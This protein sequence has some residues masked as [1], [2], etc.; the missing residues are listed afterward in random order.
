MHQ[1]ETVNADAMWASE[2]QQ[3]SADAYPQLLCG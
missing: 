1:Y 2:A 3:E